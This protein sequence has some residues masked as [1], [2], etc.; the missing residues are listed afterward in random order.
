MPPVGDVVQDEE[1][2]DALVQRI[3][4]TIEFAREAFVDAAGFRSG[5]Q[6]QHV[7]DALSE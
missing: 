1:V 2:A 7:L 5:Q 4:A 6:A 3:G